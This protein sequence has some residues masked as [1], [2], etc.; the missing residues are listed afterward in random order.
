MVSLFACHYFL[1][2]NIS[3]HFF[4]FI[5]LITVNNICLTFP[6]FG[7]KAMDCTF[8]SFNGYNKKWEMFISSDDCNQKWDVF[9]SAVECNQSYAFTAHNLSAVS[10]FIENA[11]FMLGF[12][13]FSQ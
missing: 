10:F 7:V 3:L 4:V 9:T 2:E 8:T 5:F 13:G 1:R 11:L 6:V 12:C